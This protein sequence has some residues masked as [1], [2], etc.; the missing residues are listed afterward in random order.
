ML[1]TTVHWKHAKNKT[2]KNQKKISR[3][4]LK[5]TCNFTMESGTWL[6]AQLFNPYH[7]TPPETILKEEVCKTMLT[8]GF[9]F[10][11]DVG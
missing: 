10:I 4:A 5:G 2:K 11:S 6:P 7:S 8:Y 1:E 3:V 9:F